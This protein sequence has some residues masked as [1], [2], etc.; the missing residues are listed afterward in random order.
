MHT[1]VNPTNLHLR[2]PYATYAGLRR[3]AD[4]SM[5]THAYAELAI[6][7]DRLDACHLG[8]HCSLLHRSEDVVEEGRCEEHFCDLVAL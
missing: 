2:K 3:L 8:T 4:L 1:Y 7:V 6:E 5:L